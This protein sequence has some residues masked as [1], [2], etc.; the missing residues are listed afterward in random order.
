M[1]ALL[2]VTVLV[3]LA[4]SW[5]FSRIPTL[6]SDRVCD[7]RID[8]PTIRVL[9]SQLLILVMFLF[10]FV[11]ALSAVFMTAPAISGEI[12][13]G[14][15]LAVLTRPLTRAEYLLGKWL[16]LAALVVVYVGGA[17]LLEFALVSLGTGYFPPHPYLFTAFL[18]GQTLVILT[19]AML[20]STRM[21]AMAGGIVSLGAFGASWM[22]G[23]AGNLGM[24]FQSQGIVNA[25]NVFKL[26]LPSDGLWRGAIYSLEP[27]AFIAAT[28]AN[29]GAGRGMATFPFFAGSPP[30][31]SYLAWSAAWVVA[32]L[33]L[34]VWSFWR[35]E[36]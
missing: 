10:S 29:S 8:T 26:I 31:W 6:C 18:T 4:T 25:A 32:V 7:S 19:L 15:V 36:I 13:S 5:L 30:P 27:A 16:G 33:A 21:A 12:E 2:I 24:A 9:T 14:V 28:Q 22:A 1:L 17:S 20:I 35:R 11:L 23:V 3:V 34:A